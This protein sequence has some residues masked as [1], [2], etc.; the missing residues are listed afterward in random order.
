MNTDISFVN[1]KLPAYLL[2]FIFHLGH[3]RELNSNH[4]ETTSGIAYYT[5]DVLLFV[6]SYFLRWNRR[7]L[8]SFSLSII[9]LFY[10]INI[11]FSLNPPPSSSPFI[12]FIK[13]ISKKILRGCMSVCVC[14]F[15]YLLT[16]SCVLL[17]TLKRHD[18]KDIIITALNSSPTGLCSLLD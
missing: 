4:S 15:T 13:V 14:V 1:R 5:L 12:L 17:Y 9:I 10:I 6:T 3:H 7:L 2:H 11:I 18:T 8:L 16:Y